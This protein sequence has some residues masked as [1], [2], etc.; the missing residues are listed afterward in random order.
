MIT[1][2][3]YNNKYKV[4]TKLGLVITKPYKY[5]PSQADCPKTYKQLL[6]IITL[7]DTSFNPTQN[8]KVTPE[9]QI[10]FW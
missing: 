1:Y 8:K 4:I 7:R 2:S 9:Y 10:G 3:L 5:L 6:M